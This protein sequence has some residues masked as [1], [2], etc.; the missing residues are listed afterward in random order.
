MIISVNAKPGSRT[1]EILYDDATSTVKVKISSPPESGK[2]NLHLVKF[3]STFFGISQNQ[4]E[5]ISGH[6]SRKKLIK[7]DLADEDVVKKLRM[8]I[9]ET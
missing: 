6:K 1:N 3:L 2:A 8:T 9:K 5:I 7:I 4:V